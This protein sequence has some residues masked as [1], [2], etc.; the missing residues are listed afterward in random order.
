[1]FKEI[2]NTVIGYFTS[3]SNVIKKTVADKNV[4]AS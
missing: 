3:L 4:K 1:M 2:K